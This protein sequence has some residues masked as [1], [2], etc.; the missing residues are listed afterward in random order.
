MNVVFSNT[1]AFQIL[2]YFFHINFRYCFFWGQYHP[3][4]ARG[5]NLVDKTNLDPDLYRLIVDFTGD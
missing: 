1:Y 5:C 4:L 3:Y 2:K